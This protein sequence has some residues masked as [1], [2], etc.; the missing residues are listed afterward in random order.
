MGMD[1]TKISTEK[2]LLL[3]KMMWHALKFVR[4]R[5]RKCT[6]SIGHMAA[7]ISIAVQRN[8]ACSWRITI[9]FY[10]FLLA[11]PMCKD[12]FAEMGSKIFTAF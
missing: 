11:A 6:N 5:T 1:V 12:A 4:D 8:V 10:I 9:E 3:I 7:T 2:K